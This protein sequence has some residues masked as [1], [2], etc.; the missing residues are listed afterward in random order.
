M[1]RSLPLL[2]CCSL[3][4]ISLRAAESNQVDQV[5]GS[6]VRVSVTS[7]SPNF[8]TPWVSGS[9]SSGRG[10]GFVVAG[11]MIMT[12]AHVVSNARFITLEKEGDPNSY[13]AQVVHIA[14]DC[15]L[16]LVKPDQDAFFEQTAAL[17]FGG[18]PPLESTVSVYGYPIGGDRLSVT[19]GVV[20]RIDFLPYSHS[21]VDSHLTIQIDAAINPGNSGGPVMADNKVV[22]VAF[23]GYSGDVAQNVG[24]MIPT[25]V[26]KRFLQDVEDGQYD[27]YVDLSI[28]T[29]KLI[30]PAQR[31]ALAIDDKYANQGIMVSHVLPQGSCDGYLQIGDVLLE[32]DGLPIAKDGMV[33]IDGELVEMSETVER[34]FLGDQV[35]FKLL[36]DQQVM[37]VSP[38]LKTAQPFRMLANRYGVKPRYIMFGGLLLQPLS[39]DLISAFRFS[40][41]RINYYFNRYVT[42]EIYAEHP[43]LVILTTVLNDPVNAYISE[44]APAI[45][46]TINDQ[47]IQSLEDAAAALDQDVDFHILK[48][49]GSSRP[50]VLA[51]SDVAEAMP[52]IAQRY[53]IEKIR[54]LDE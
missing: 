39:R 28:E 20:S 36:R 26:V 34:K 37:E 19:R 6:L 14:H 47:K 2:L 9:T 22:G 29:F 23:Q 5:R 10:A 38:K 12:N 21:A 42:D 48:L 32:I 3:A 18:I 13:P 51:N 17:E 24:Y 49:I 27:R 25:P 7:Q 11:Q 31:Q 53:N 4:T 43:E 54:N 50:L 30:N 52:R 16:A 8:R 46:D 45:I 40:D 33:R 35:T 44:Y 15:D 1:H 41:L